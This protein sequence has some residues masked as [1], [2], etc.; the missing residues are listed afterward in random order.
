MKNHWRTLSTLALVATVVPVQA[1]EADTDQALQAV[2]TLRLPEADKVSMLRM[3][4]GSILWGEITA[5]TPDGITFARLDS[6]GLATLNWSFLDPAQ[7]AELRLQFGYVDLEGEDIMVEGDRITLVDSS[8]MIGKILE[9]TP[10]SIVLKTAFSSAIEIPLT[11]VRATSP[12]TVAASEVYTRE[13]LYVQELVLSDEE[14]AESQYELGKFCERILDYAHAVEHYEKAIE[15]D[16]TFRAE[17]LP[18]LLTRAEERAALQEQV[19]FLANIDSLK[20]RKHFDD[21]LDRVAEFPELYPGSPLQE[22]LLRI[23]DSVLKARDRF[24]LTTVFK[25]WLYVAGRKARTA[26]I[27]MGVDEAQT[28]ATEAMSEE[29]ALAVT[30]HVQKWARDIPAEDVRKYWTER[31]KGRFRTIS[32]GSGTWL[33]G[34]A[35]ALK[36]MD[37]PEEEKPEENLSESE[38][39]RRALEEKLR[40]FMENRQRRQR[41]AASE[42]ESADRE[43]WWKHA[44]QGDRQRWIFAY[45]VEN[46][47]DFELRD[48]VLLHNCRQCGGKGVKEI[49]YTGGARSTDTGNGGG[50]GRGRRNPQNGGSGIGLEECGTC[51]GIGRTR[52]IQYR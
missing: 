50:R 9:R 48:K 30:E 35:A 26:A 51:K 27:T 4:N 3:K 21:A 5:H 41:R 28:Y 13:E 33:L 46:A 22:K 32:Y 43:D 47:G 1:Q 7:E 19:D 20:R 36:G 38:K 40:V 18:N 11:R 12:V 49:I 39:Q 52:R 8:E 10:T 14:S 6:G 25:R 29:I 34:E 42:D 15:L 44:S 23:R 16:P 17:E 24:M 37:A 31:K 45:Y 2:T